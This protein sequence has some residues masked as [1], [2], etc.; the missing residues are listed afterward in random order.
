MLGGNP[1]KSGDGHACQDQHKNR[2]EFLCTEFH[3]LNPSHVFGFGMVDG[4]P[5]CASDEDDVD[6]VYMISGVTCGE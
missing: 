2:Y 6:G 3:L 1:E 5:R 4:C